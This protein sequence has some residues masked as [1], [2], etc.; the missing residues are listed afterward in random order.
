MYVDFFKYL[1]NGRSDIDLQLL[2]L[3]FGVLHRG[4]RNRGQYFANQNKYKSSKITAYKSVCS[5]KAKKGSKLGGFWK[6]MIKPTNT[7]LYLFCLESIIPQ[8]KFAG[9]RCAIL[10]AHPLQKRSYGLVHVFYKG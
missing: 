2:K 8:N 1:R 5:N 9:L 4:R 10:C 6:P 3:K 7:K